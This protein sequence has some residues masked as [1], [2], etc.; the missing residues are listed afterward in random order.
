MN[1]ETFHEI[2]RLIEADITPG[3]PLCGGQKVINPAERL[4]L[5][6]RF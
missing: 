3:Q 4:V 5:T 1:S 2:L 6:L